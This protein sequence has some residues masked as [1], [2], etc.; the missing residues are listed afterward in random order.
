M[1]RKFWLL[2][3]RREERFSFIHNVQ[4][5]SGAHPASYSLGTEILS[6]W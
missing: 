5:G 2:N 4:T 3:P 1:D 6:L